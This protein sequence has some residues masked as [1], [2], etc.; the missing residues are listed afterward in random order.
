MHA[1]IINGQIV[2]FPYNFMDLRWD[3]PN[4]SFPI[5][6]P[7]E[8]LATFNMVRVFEQERP[9]VDRFH[10]ATQKDLPDLV[11]G[12]WVLQ[13]VVT[14]KTEEQ[15]AQDTEDKAAEIR[16]QR[17][18]KLTDSD[19]TQVADAPVDK[20]VWLAYRQALR[21]LPLQPGFP[22]EVTWPIRPSA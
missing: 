14:A 9:E 12:Q 20:T 10:V 2:Q 1:K 15:L 7:D 3:Y 22:W 4:V 6:M 8:Q 11:N 16:G 19:W 21:E 13:W 18:G 5:D 17:N